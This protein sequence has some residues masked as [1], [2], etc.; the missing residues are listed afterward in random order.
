MNKKPALTALVRGPV[1]LA[2]DRRVTRSETGA[3][4]VRVRPAAENGFV[5]SEPSTAPPGIR[6]AFDARFRTGAGETKTVKLIDY[7]SAGGTWGPESQ[8]RVWFPRHLDL[9][10]PF[11]GVP[12]ETT[13]H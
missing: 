2:L 9:H 7:S 13:H 4:P 5:E 11:A 3:E 10:D 12:G 8:F 1:A 6:L